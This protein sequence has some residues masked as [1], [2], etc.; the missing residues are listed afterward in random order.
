MQRSSTLDSWSVGDSLYQLTTSSVLANPYPFFEQIQRLGPLYFDETVQAYVCTNFEM[1][2]D[3]LQ[4]RHAFW[5]K[6]IVVSRCEDNRCPA[7][8]TTGPGGQF[9]LASASS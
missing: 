4:Q 3:I 8:A 7:T 6:Y 2:R 5:C 9:F 1:G